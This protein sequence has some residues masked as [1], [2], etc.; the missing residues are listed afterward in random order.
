MKISE[1]ARR[2]LLADSLEEKLE[3]VDVAALIDEECGRAIEASVEPGRPVE[4]KMRLKGGEHSL[5]KPNITEVSDDEERGRL[6]HFFANHELLAT[7]LMALVLLK[8]P[9]AP[10]EFRQGVLRT[11]KEEQRHTRWYI[12]RMKECGVKFGDF[13][14]S[15]YF[16]DMVATMET[17]LDYVTRLSLTF[18]QANLDYSL[19]YAGIMEEAGDSKSAAILN[20][21]YK[22]EIRHVNYGLKWFR[23]WKKADEDDWTAFKRGLSFPL[24]PRRAK[25]SGP[26]I[27]REGRLAAGLDED[28]ISELEVFERSVGRTP[29]MFCFCPDAEDAMSAN[30]EG[31]GYHRSKTMQGLIQDL[32]ILSIFLARR[33]DVVLMQRQPER[34]HLEKLRRAG[35]DLPE[36]ELLDKSG[37]IKADSFIRERKINAFRP[38]AWCPSSARMMSPL[39]KNLPGDERKMNSFWNEGVRSLFNKSFGAGIAE[40]R[41]DSVSSV[42]CRSLDAVEAE[43]RCLYQAVVKTPFGA[44]GR[45]L[46]IIGSSDTLDGSIRRQVE[47]VLEKQ[48]EVLVEPWLTRELD[49]SVQ[50]EMEDAGLRKL[51][52]V[53]LENNSRGQ[54]RACVVGT[55]FCQGMP[56]ELARFLM[57][58]ALPVYEEEGRLVRLIEEGLNE[59]GYRG[60]VGVD[61]FVY[62]DEKGEL[63]LRQL[64]EVNP[65]YTMGRLTLE[66]S[67][68]VAPGHAVKFE[69]LKKQSE[70]ESEVIELDQKGFFCRGRMCLNDGGKV[71]GFLAQLKVSKRLDDLI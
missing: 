61:A 25:G 42:L 38:W 15:R 49:F 11:L 66:L 9:D 32:E 51:G 52:L 16:W 12:E 20:Q 24:S 5:A 63:C 29:N 58:K 35:F 64:C 37:E 41:G 62:R 57:E 69:I 27:N 67:K 31:K 6:L 56:T 46:N 1:F 70:P 45:G 60:P 8:F 39:A 55:K 34:K 17:P 21:I 33:D 54:F 48:G 36:I 71:G 3:F 10:G 28:F 53:R 13:P 47:R 7:E 40:E 14:V 68:R 50:Y 4:L 2:V 43:L 65:R 18:E 22:D 26:K 19:Q 44:S 59:V 30:V 23:R